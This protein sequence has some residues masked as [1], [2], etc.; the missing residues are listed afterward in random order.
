MQRLRELIGP[1]AGPSGYD[2][3]GSLYAAGAVGER[4]S[5]AGRRET[6]PGATDGDIDPNRAGRG[7]T[8]RPTPGDRP[9]RT[10][11]S[12]TEEPPERDARAELLAALRSPSSLRTAILLREVLDAPVALRDDPRQR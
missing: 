11:R 3:P 4:A 10:V 7:E 9:V 1:A 6:R 8:V 2:R 5:A 12:T